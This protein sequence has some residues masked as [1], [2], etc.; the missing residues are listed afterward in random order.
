MRNMLLFRLLS[1]LKVNVSLSLIGRFFSLF[2]FPKVYDDI[3]ISLSLSWTRFTQHLETL[4]WSLVKLGS[5][6]IISSSTFSVLPFFSF[7]PRILMTWMLDLT[8]ITPV[9]DR[10]SVYFF[11]CIF[12]LFFRLSHFY[13]F[14]LK[15]HWFFF[16]PSILLLWFLF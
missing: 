9:P 15:F 4:G 5:L 6:T 11:N 16:Y 13:C 14:I 10:D 12:Y 2:R 1:P 7:P 8:L 3:W